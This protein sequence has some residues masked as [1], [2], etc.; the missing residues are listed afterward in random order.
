MQFR[1][2]MVH[3]NP[4]EAP[5]TTAFRDPRHL[6]SY[7]FN[8][9]VFKHLNCVAKFAATGV[10]VF[11][12]GSPDQVWLDQ[13]T[14][15]IENEIAAAKE[16][17]LQVFYHLDLFVLPKRLVA[18]FGNELHDSEGRISLRRRKTRELQAMLFDEL[19]QRFPQVDGYIIRV[20]ETYLHDTPYH[21]GNGAVP[22]MVADWSADYQYAEMLRGTPAAASWNQTHVSAFVELL[23][24]LRDE[25]CERLGKYVFFRT[26]D[27][28][29]D[30]LHARPDHYLHVTDQIEPHAKLLFSIKHTALDFWRHVK[31][32]DC[33]GRGRHA[34]VVEVQCQREYEGKGAFPNYFADRLLHGFE[35]NTPSRG[36][37]ELV[38]NPLI[39]GIYTWSRGGGWYGPYITR[40]L[41]PDLMMYV[42]GHFGSDPRR[43]E[44]ELFSMYAREKLTLS[45]SDVKKF[46]ELCE[47][48]SVAVLKGRYCAAFDAQLRGE[49]LP[50][51]NWMR[52]D[53]LGG[54]EQL[55]PVLLWLW[56]KKQ[57]DAALREK[58]EAVTLWERIVQLALEIEWADADTA[59][60]VQVSAMYG[61]A[62]FSIVLEGW[63]VMAAGTAGEQTGVWDKPT[64]TDAALRY[65]Q[66]WENFRMLARSPHCPSLYR[67]CYLFRA[68][69]A[70]VAGLDES[71]EYFS[72][73]IAAPS[74]SSSGLR[75]KSR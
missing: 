18:H 57:F 65:Q 6:A 69:E 34:Q 10:N 58:S 49:L 29:P 23:Q 28:F 37:S 53:R 42:L 50:T 38:K 72:R 41:W 21:I 60:F 19:A 26:W 36:L 7:G 3:H 43:E 15:S 40:E 44:T 54:R 63:R 39:R 74:L 52:D 55:R 12:P 25:V 33:L 30:K 48:S 5:F 51:A 17:G 13:R 64:I 31:P 2:D 8:G 45:S 46:R 59:E 47:L 16:V 68:G 9:Q 71:V 66:N 22:G 56:E 35:E 70:P 24:F 1:F 32:N 4:G 11:P 20:G 61:Y 73:K 67:G 62:L 14:A 75:T 27:M